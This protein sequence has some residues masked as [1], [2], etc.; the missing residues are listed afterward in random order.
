M[1]RFETLLLSLALLATWPALASARELRLEAGGNLQ[2]SV[3]LAKPG[4]VL[5]VGPGTYA[6]PVAFSVPHLTV[7]GEGEPV[8]DGQGKG[9]VALIVAPGVTLRGF[10]LTHSGTSPYGDDA[11]VKL[12]S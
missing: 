2:Q 3:A 10:H 1:A 12:I 4:D 11:G 5:R 9:S 8:I 6:G 7:I